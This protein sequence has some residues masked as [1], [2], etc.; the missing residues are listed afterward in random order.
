MQESFTTTLEHSIFAPILGESDGQPEIDQP[1]SAQPTNV[2]EDLRNLLGVEYVLAGDESLD[3]YAKTTLPGGTRP[4]AIVLPNT[5]EQVCDIAKI[6]RRYGIELHAI[7]LGKNWGYGDACAPTDGQIIVDL[8]RMNRIREVNVELG[9]AIIEPGVSQGQM[10]RYLR[11]NNLPLLLDVTGAGPEASIVGNILQRGFG[12]T[13][14]GDRFRHTSG[15]EV[16]LRDGRVTKTGFGKFDNAKAAEVFPWGVG[17]WIDGLFTQS[18]FGIVTSACVW[19]MPKPEV[20]EGFAFSFSDEKLG[21]VLDAIRRLRLNGTIRSTVHIA[22]DLRVLSSRTT[23]P[24]DQAGD[25]TPLP[26]ALRESLRRKYGLKAWNVLGG[27]YGS[28]AEVR[29][30][31]KALRKELAGLAKV[32]SFQ[33]RKLHLAERVS[34]FLSFCR[35]GRQLEETVGSVSSAYDLLRGV[36]N[37][38]HLR[39]AHWR[40][41]QGASTDGESVRNAGLIWISPVLPMTSGAA[42][43]VLEVA[44]PLFHAHGFDLL[45][46]MTAITERALCCVMSIN[47]DKTDACEVKNARKCA[48]TLHSTLCGLGYYPYRTPSIGY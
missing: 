41:R 29:A 7:S 45:V 4:S 38:E 10:Y 39:G 21:N 12:H 36:P 13:P 46:T 20:I 28:R 42:R 15:L 33:S 14:Y 43:E 1:A 16:V 9:Y 32:H 31:R 37:S 2:L 3:A 44:E 22:N 30:S 11:D 5:T 26:P 18:D 25:A 34:K 23:Y 27:L 40:T 8:K 47:Y 48:E 17:P 6:A 24:W 19:L 35:F